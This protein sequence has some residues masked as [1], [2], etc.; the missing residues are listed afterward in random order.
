MIEELVFTCAVYRR[1]RRSE[2][3]AQCGGCSADLTS[4]G[5]PGGGSWEIAIEAA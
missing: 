4:C 2:R 5:P 3:D 1:R